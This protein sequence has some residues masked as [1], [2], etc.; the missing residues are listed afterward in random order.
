M[1]Q[2]K[3]GWGKNCNIVIFNDYLTFY[4]LDLS[5]LNQIPNN[6]PKFLSSFYFWCCK[7]NYSEYTHT[8][9]YA[10][11]LL[12]WIKGFVLRVVV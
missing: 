6:R 7:E 4:Y 9:I 11:K 2:Q 3:K 1:L 12:L 5:F 10:H 8:H